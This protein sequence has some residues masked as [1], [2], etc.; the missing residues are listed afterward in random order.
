MFK[1]NL[2]LEDFNRLR[3]RK[4]KDQLKRELEIAKEDADYFSSEVIQ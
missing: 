4:D 2:N 1:N 3:G